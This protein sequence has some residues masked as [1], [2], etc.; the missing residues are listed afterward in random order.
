MGRPCTRVLP[1]PPPCYV[2]L[3]A[4]RPFSLRRALPLAA[5]VVWLTESCCSR[6]ETSGGF[7]RPLFI[8]PR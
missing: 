1:K 8:Q 4:P 6:I 2:E 7:G 5:L 3:E